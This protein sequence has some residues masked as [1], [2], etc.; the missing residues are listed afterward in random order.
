MNSL[1]F[2]RFELGRAQ[3]QLAEFF[4]EMPAS[5]TKGVETESCHAIAH[6]QQ[7]NLERGAQRSETLPGKSAFGLLGH[8]V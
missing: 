3:A 8:K 1:V 2:L 6:R 7:V 5:S 4:G